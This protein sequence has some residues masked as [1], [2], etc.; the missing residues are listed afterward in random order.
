MKALYAYPDHEIVDELLPHARD[1]HLSVE[2][3]LAR[4]TAT[5][6]L[7]PL[8]IDHRDGG[9]V[10]WGD[11]GTHP[12]RE[13]QYMYSIQQLAQS[14]EMGAVFTTPFDILLHDEVAAE[15]IAP[16]GFIFHIS[17]CGSTL[18]AKALA[19]SDHH[20]VIN[21]GAPL[22]RGFWATITGDWAGT[23]DPTPEN[24]RLFRNLVLAMT[25]KRTPDQTRSFV[26][27]IS[28]NSLYMNFAMQAFPTVP[29][30]FLYRDP[31]EV[32]ASVLRETTAA[33]WAKKR[34]QAGFL[35][36]GDWQKTAAMTDT[37]YLTRCFAH[38]FKVALHA[39]P[40]RLSH[41]NYTNISA[42]TF[43]DILDRGLDF[44]PTAA[45]LDL[46]AEQFQYHSKDDSDKKAF[47]ADGAEK[48]AEMPPADRQMIAQATDGL[49][50]NLDRAA[51]NLFS[52]QLPG[53]AE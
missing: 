17:R 50:Q 45:D 3:G 40:A 47:K 44:R 36:D 2:D 12:F 13:W 15:G 22:Q 30:L 25:R 34:P 26:K 48:R 11:M 23:T 1:E 10:I 42:E 8:A 51:N 52:H 5:P 14:G 21:Q 43:P 39:D 16:S 7:V 27:F 28:W 18:L 31:V 35:V 20:V 33:L 24:L 46:M 49:I 41:L 38:Y 29:S 32:I 53:A 4:I 37:D 19:R 9:T 6:G